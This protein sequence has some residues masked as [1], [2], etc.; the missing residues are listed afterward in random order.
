MST[1]NENVTLTFSANGK[2]IAT[3]V[4]RLVTENVDW[5]RTKRT[6]VRGI[7][8][9]ARALGVNRSHLYRVIRGQRKS[10]SLIRRYEVWRKTR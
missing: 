10:E 8:E 6:R 9:A 4:G 7:C 5:R 1:D 2:A 3:F